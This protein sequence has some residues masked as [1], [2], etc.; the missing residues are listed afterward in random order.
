MP[1]SLLSPFLRLSSTVS[2]PTGFL[3]VLTHSSS[4]CIWIIAEAPQ[5]AGA[6]SLSTLSVSSRL[7]VHSEILETDF[8]EL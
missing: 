6:T 8:Y 5:T 7:A 4:L 1:L 2:S 3:E